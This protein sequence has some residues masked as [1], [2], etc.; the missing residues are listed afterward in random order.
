MGVD[1][2]ITVHFTATCDDCSKFTREYTTQSAAWRGL[3][4]HKQECEATKHDCGVC[5]TSLHAC[6]GFILRRGKG[7]CEECYETDTHH[8]TLEVSVASM[9]LAEKRRGRK[10]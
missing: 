6:S 7:C 3:D 9:K 8:A 2:T 10:K 1:K 4:R 5:D